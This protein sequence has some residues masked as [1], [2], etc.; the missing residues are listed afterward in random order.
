MVDSAV[1]EFGCYHVIYDVMFEDLVV[2]F[3]SSF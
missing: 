1:D 3:G 2:L